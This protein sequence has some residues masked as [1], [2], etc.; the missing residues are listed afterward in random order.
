MGNHKPVPY[1][2]RSVAFSDTD[3]KYSEVQIKRS[4]DITYENSWDT[5]KFVSF[6]RALSPLPMRK[7]SMLVDR[8]KKLLMFALKYALGGRMLCSRSSHVTRNG[9]H[10][11]T[12][13]TQNGTAGKALTQ[14]C[15]E[16]W[17]SRSDLL[18]SVSDSIHRFDM[19]IYN[20][21]HSIHGGYA[22][23]SQIPN[24]DTYEAF[25]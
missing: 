21:V 15:K 19:E 8:G 9:F 23:F 5:A 2:L 10:G 17:D 20:Q 6:L 1:L 18:S 4:R 25:V 13:S 22:I 7:V 3:Y 16:S 24:D 11:L 12:L 14:I